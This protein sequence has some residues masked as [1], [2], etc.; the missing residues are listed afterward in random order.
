MSQPVAIESLEPRTLLS[1]VRPTVVGY[2]PDYHVADMYSEGSA[3]LDRINWG[4][5]TQINYF[6][7]VPDA[8]TGAL[9]GTKPDATSDPLPAVSSNGN[10][11]EQLNEVVTEAHSHH[12][13][14]S[15]VIGG[16]GHDDT[17][18]TILSD[19]DLRAKFADSVQAFAETYGVDGVDLDWELQHPWQYQIDDYGTLIETLR[20]RTTGLKITAAVYPQKLSIATQDDPTGGNYDTFA[21]QL[22]P[23]AITNLD[24]IGIMDYDLDFSDHSPVQA[25]EQNM[26]AWAD[27]LNTNG[28]PASKLLFGIPFYGKAGKSWN[29]HDSDNMPYNLLID[30][31][32][33]NNTPQADLDLNQVT[34]PLST[35][36]PS[37]FT[38]VYHFNSVNDVQAKTKYALDH[39]FGG[40]L[41]WDIGMD[42]LVGANVDD[43]PYSLLA[44]IKRSMVTNYHPGFGFSDLV[45]VAQHYGMTSEATWE[46]GDYNLDGSVDFADLVMVA[47]GYGTAPAPAA[48]PASY[49]QAKALSAPIKPVFS[50]KPVV[51]H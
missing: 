7:V 40:V 8:T 11:L 19:E 26:D 49:L 45:A 18:T 3:T 27:Y 13:K 42:H 10:S 46:Q 28:A 35:I 31:Y 1:A 33:A 12:V 43:D 39:H 2:L 25:S 50:V 41:A 32:N 30:T 15:I 9:P 21:W 44:G 4:A 23:T 47:Q 14:V 5:L 22:S 51:H 48:A 34:A 37:D 36:L 16:A 20:S 38:Q 24:Q 29:W 6:S 17:L